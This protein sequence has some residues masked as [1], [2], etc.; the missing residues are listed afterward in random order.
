[1]IPRPRSVRNLMTFLLLI[2]L[3]PSSLLF[4]TNSQLFP[5]Q[6]CYIRIIC[7][8]GVHQLRTMTN[9]QRTSS[10]NDDPRFCRQ[11]R[12]CRTSFLFSVVPPPSPPQAQRLP[13]A[14]IMTKTNSWVAKNLFRSARYFM[15]APPQ[16][17]PQGWETWR[18]Q[19]HRSCG[20]PPPL[21]APQLHSSQIHYSQRRRDPLR[22]AQRSSSCRQDADHL[23]PISLSGMMMGA[24]GAI[25]AVRE[26]EIS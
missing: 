23:R 9:Q 17:S 26:A 12:G 3:A 4:M 2:N 11:T 5:N 24:G 8:S 13:S 10:W 6:T 19:F 16:I 7:W 14:E 25:Q 15:S 18:N 22:R 1:M 20:S 21:T